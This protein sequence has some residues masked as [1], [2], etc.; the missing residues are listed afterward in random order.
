MRFYSLRMRCQ[1]IKERFRF[2]IQERR[3]NRVYRRL[4]ITYK[5]CKVVMKAATHNMPS[6]RNKQEQ[7]VKQV[8]TLL[9][10][11]KHCIFC[12]ETSY[13]LWD[14]KRI[15]KTWQKEND[16]ITYVCNTQRLQNVTIYGAVS[17]Q[18][19]ELLF[20]QGT[21]TNTE[22]WRKFLIKIIR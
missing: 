10:E 18:L 7:F 1:I 14:R 17:N 5:P 12:D 6:R 13:N 3:L 8:A 16:P 4:G 2:I 21:K 20:M 9:F 22:Q 11:N 19:P 15:S